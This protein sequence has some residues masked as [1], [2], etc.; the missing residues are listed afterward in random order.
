MTD[1]R[2]GDWVEFR[3]DDDGRS[4]AKLSYVSPLKGTYLFVNRQGAKVGEYSL[5]QLAREFRTGR[6][7]LPRSR[8][9]VGPCHERS[10][11]RSQEEH[12]LALQRWPTR[13]IRGT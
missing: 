6:A 13:S 9:A 2:E 10:G 7:V 4:Q 8:P 1:L 12:A 11:R 3:D 5:Y